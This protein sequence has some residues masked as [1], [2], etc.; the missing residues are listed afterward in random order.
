MVKGLRVPTVAE[1]LRI[2]GY[3][4]TKRNTTRD[5]IDFVALFDHFGAEKSLKA[6]ASLDD[7]YPQ[8]GEESVL[9]Q[10]ATQLAEPKPWDLTETDLSHYKS[11]KEPYTDWNEIKRRAGAAGLRILESLLV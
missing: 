2:K 10:L 9:K 11:L 1:I 3:L 7:L 8:E 5:F 6:L 4:I